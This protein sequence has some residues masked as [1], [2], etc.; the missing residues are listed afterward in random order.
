MRFW[1]TVLALVLLFRLAI[2]RGGQPEIF[3][4]VTFIASFA[5]ILAMRIMTGIP[6]FIFF[7]PLLFTVDFVIQGVFFWVALR[8]NRFWTLCIC[9]LQLIVL[10][11]HLAKLLHV[12]GMAGVYWGMTTIPIYVEY[13]FLL[14]AIRIHARRVEKFGL[15]PDWQSDLTLR[16]LDGSASY[17][18]ERN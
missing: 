10:V 15:Y 1:L 3:V 2:R 8:A 13:L 18:G 6:N 9:S 12:R 16:P 17:E 5:I 11:T 14:I 7:D 4:S